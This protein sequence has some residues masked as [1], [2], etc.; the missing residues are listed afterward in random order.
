MNH[1]ALKA[2]ITAIVILIA[3]LFGEAGFVM[4]GPQDDAYAQETD[5]TKILTVF[6]EPGMPTIGGTKLT[7]SGLGL[8]T[9]VTPAD[10]TGYKI[11]WKSSDTDAAT[12]DE[13]GYVHGTLTGKYSGANEAT[14]QIT[15][16]VSLNGKTDSDTVT[17]KVKRGYDYQRIDVPSELSVSVGETS[18]ELVA[19]L[20]PTENPAGEN[21]LEYFFV[22]QDPSIAFVDEYGYVTG[23][24]AGETDIIVYTLTGKTT[25]CHV[26]VTGGDSGT[27]AGAGDSASG[28]SSLSSESSI[29]PNEILICYDADVSNKE[30]RSVLSDHDAEA[31]ALTKSGEDEKIVLA[32]LSESTDIE[33][34]MKEVKADD[35]IRYVQPNYRYKLYSSA[36]PYYA[37]VDLSSAYPYSTINQYFH[38]QSRFN[39]AWNLLESNGISQT[40][41]VGVIDSGVDTTHLDLTPNLVLNSDNTYT[42]FRNGKEVHDTSDIV[43]NMHGTH[44][45]G[46]IGAVYGN[47]IGG[48]GAASGKSNNYSKVMT[49]GIVSDSRGDLSSYDIIL[50]IQHAVRNGAKVINMSFGGPVRDRLL[51]TAIQ[52]HYYNDGVV[53]VGSAGNDRSDYTGQDYSIYDFSHPADL[54]EVISVCNVKREGSKDGTNTNYGFA[55]DISAPGYRI[56]STGKAP[57]GMVVLSGTSMSAPVVSAAC[58]L[59]LDANPDLTPE[60]VRNIICGTSSDPS[61]YFKSNELGYGELDAYEA[62]KAAYKAKAA[63]SSSEIYIKIKEPYTGNL[64]TKETISSVKGSVAKPAGIAVKKS[65]TVIRYSFKK[66]VFTLTKTVKVIAKDM[67]TGKKTVERSSTKTSK[68]KKGVKY[69]IGIR[70]KG[71]SWKY[72]KLAAVNKSKSRY[73]VTAK[74]D[75]IYVRFR[76]LK[77]KS[78]YYV[79]LRAYRKSGGKTYYSKWTAKKKVKTK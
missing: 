25:T 54:K 62:V 27:P 42:A 1:R 24:K 18:E 34:L 28:I 49:V 73:S 37:D 65:K 30:I 47:G 68:T 72:Y 69:Q 16:T 53:F 38:F 32:T 7:E 71:G 35:S 63:A 57:Q 75:R 79:R 45:T 11:T 41:T 76:K 29:S 48:A 51:G 66:P 67:F 70:K 22:S 44:V 33:G 43:S 14:C 5:S 26:T 52:N 31:D 60:E 8:D 46:I 10:A 15:A 9:L 61:L 64:I 40:T 17:V 13:H 19:N 4:S 6:T 58:A 2:R 78:V 77:K 50:A 23:M 39:D 59:L 55:K 74:G 21:R 20:N 56:Y 36:D 3:L 12:V